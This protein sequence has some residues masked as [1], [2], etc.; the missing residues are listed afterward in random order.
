MTRTAA[1]W[2]VPLAVV[3]AVLLGGVLVALLTP[4]RPPSSYLDPAN[5]AGQGTR[6]LAQIL[7]QRGQPVTAVSSAAAAQNAVRDA[8]GGSSGGAPAAGPGSS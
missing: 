7:G 2:R 8:A 5:P 6:A 3:A 4:S 1:R